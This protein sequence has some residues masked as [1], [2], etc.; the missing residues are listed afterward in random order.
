M[1][2][3]SNWDQTQNI[4]V[5]QKSTSIATKLKNSNCDNLKNHI[6]TKLKKKSNFENPNGKNLKSQ[7]A[8]KLKL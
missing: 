8:T 5:G 1:I 4:K 6:A 7:I 2:Q 3:N